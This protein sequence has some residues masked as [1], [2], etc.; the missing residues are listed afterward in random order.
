[1]AGSHDAFWLIFL[2]VVA[3]AML[4]W[5]KGSEDLMAPFPCSFRY[6]ICPFD[7]ATQNPGEI[8]L[9]YVKMTRPSRPRSVLAPRAMWITDQL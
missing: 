1:M 6:E 3:F 2:D 8:S 9:G 5:C 4:S 7:R